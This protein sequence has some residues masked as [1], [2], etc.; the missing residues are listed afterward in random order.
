LEQARLI[1]LQRSHDK[2]LEEMTWI[3]D[4]IDAL[5]QMMQWNNL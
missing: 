4:R 2:I 1:G 5:M 3:H